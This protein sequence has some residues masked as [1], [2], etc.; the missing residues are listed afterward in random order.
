M[1]ILEALGVERENINKS[2]AI[3]TLHPIHLIDIV[4]LGIVYY[5]NSNLYDFIYYHRYR[6]DR[7]RVYARMMAE[8]N[9]E[10]RQGIV[11]LPDSE[12]LK[13]S[14]GVTDEQLLSKY[15][16]NPE[17]RVDLENEMQLN[18]PDSA[19]ILECFEVEELAKLIDQSKI[20][21]REESVNFEQDN[22][23]VLGSKLYLS[24]AQIDDLVKLEPSL[25]V[26]STELLLHNIKS[27]AYLVGKQ[28]VK[29]VALA[30]PEYLVNDNNMLCDCLCDM[31]E[32][33]GMTR[34]Q[35][36]NALLCV[37]DVVVE[38]ELNVESSEQDS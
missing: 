23:F 13:Y 37:A 4:R 21:N 29:K 12:F 9:G 28:N 34:A 26:V 24:N 6:Q 17:S 30:K 14:G 36:G 33:S 38:N 22:R 8:R 31:F 25:R 32:S 1:Q 16:L 10:I 5:E 15:K 19:K 35:F 27:L 20:K 3:L 11:Y 18:F 2:V 7:N